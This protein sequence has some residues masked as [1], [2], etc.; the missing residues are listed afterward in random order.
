MA[1]SFTLLIQSTPTNSPIY[2]NKG[3]TTTTQ[4]DAYHLDCN[5]QSQ[6]VKI[7]GL[8]PD[9]CLSSADCLKSS[10]GNSGYSGYCL[11]GLGPTSC[12]SMADCKG[13]HT[14]CENVDYGSPNGY[15]MCAIESGVGISQCD[16]TKGSKNNPDCSNRHHNICNLGYCY[17]AP[18]FGFDQCDVGIDS[19]CRSVSLISVCSATKTGGYYRCVQ[20][21]GT[22]KSQ[23]TKEID[24]NINRILPVSVN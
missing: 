18:G 3:V 14:E 4:A 10:C 8:R 19:Q 20:V 13:Y 17:T 24:C 12:T 16:I 1:V 7:G 23:C 15:E 6:C 21:S 11:P 9:R 5:R 22:G 2:E